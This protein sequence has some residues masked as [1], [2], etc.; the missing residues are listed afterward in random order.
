MPDYMWKLLTLEDNLL[1][2]TNSQQWLLVKSGNWRYCGSLFSCWSWWRRIVKTCTSP[3]VS[4]P[5]LSSEPHAFPS[6]R[7]FCCWSA[8]TRSSREPTSMLLG[9]RWF[10]YAPGWYLLQWLFFLLHIVLT[11][12][13]FWSRLTEPIF[14]SGREG[15]MNWKFLL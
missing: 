4:L 13:F 9:V 10:F 12:C 5:L 6:P 15:Y 7:R 2:L 3:A 8:R 1:G 14:H 11:W